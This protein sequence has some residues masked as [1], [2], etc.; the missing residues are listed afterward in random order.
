MG[1]VL[2]GRD[3][4]GVRRRVGALPWCVL[5]TLAALPSVDGVVSA[6]TRSLA[7][8]LGVS[9]NATHRALGVLVAAGLV[10]AMQPRSPVGRFE[11]GG[12]RVSVPASVLAPAAPP[13]LPLASGVARRRAVAA[14]VAVLSLFPA[15]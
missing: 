13:R 2:L 7:V 12:Y 6:S 4:P 10:E 11:R 3:A 8:E 5:E 1:P 15:G 9:R 14:D